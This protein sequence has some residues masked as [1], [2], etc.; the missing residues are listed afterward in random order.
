MHSLP[1]CVDCK[2]ILSL[3]AS[4]YFVVFVCLNTFYPCLFV[5]RFVINIAINFDK[6]S[7]P[8]YV[9]EKSE[10]EKERKKKT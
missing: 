9:I 10:R 4:E 1:R 3:D 8:M 7:N 6:D 5:A 2:C